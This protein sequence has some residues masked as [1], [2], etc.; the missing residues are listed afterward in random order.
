MSHSLIG[1][2]K[3]LV[4]GHSLLTVVLQWHETL[5]GILEDRTSLF[6]LDHVPDLWESFSNKGTGKVE[7]VQ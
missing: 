2:R 5:Y 1:R 6:F 7:Q 3:C 4:H